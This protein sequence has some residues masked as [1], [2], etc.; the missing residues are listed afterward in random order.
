MAYK[1]YKE[2][3]RLLK[4]LKNDLSVDKAMDIA[5]TISTVTFSL[6]DGTAV[7]QTMLTTHEQR[8]LAP[9]LP[10]HN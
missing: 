6:K 5:K 9:L 3:E 10:N 4:T 7:A 8:M 2:L 1:V